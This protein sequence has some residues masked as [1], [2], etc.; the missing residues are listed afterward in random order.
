MLLNLITIDTTDPKLSKMHISSFKGGY[1]ACH[2]KIYEEIQGIYQPNFTY[3][4]QNVYKD[5]KFEAR[6]MLSKWLGFP[7]FKLWYAYRRSAYKKKNVYFSYENESRNEL[8]LHWGRGREKINY[9]VIL[10]GVY[11]IYILEKQ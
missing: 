1:K 3:L 11:L 8:F 5:L 10:Y 2:K 4:R 7:Q 9:S 6:H